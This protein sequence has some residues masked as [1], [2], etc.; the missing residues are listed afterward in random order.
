MSAARRSL[1]VDWMTT[2]SD[3][4]LGLQSE[5][6]FLAV[7]VLDRFLATTLVAAEC[8]QLLAVTAIFIAAKMVGYSFFNLEFLSISIPFVN[9]LCSSAQRRGNLDV[10]GFPT[11]SRIFKTISL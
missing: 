7:N 5:T 10:H 2:L 9:I 6:L 4:E 8:F 3:G 11:G 1:L